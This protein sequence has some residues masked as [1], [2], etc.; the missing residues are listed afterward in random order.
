MVSSLVIGSSKGIGNSISKKLI[1][2][3]HKVIGV[4][5]S[6]HEIKSD[7]FSHFTLDVSNSNSFLEFLEKPLIKKVDNIILCA[8]TNDVAPLGDISEDRIIKLYKVNLFPAFNLL[9]KISQKDD[10]P[11][12]IVFISSIWS[13][14]GITGRSMYGTSKGALVALAKHAS[15]ELSKN[16][17]FVNCISPGFTKT[18]L[19]N[20]T[21]DDPDIIKS[22]KRT[23]FNKMQ[24]TSAISESIIM[25]L[26]PNNHGITGQE[27]F[28]D[29]GFSAH[30]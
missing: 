14:F 21:K 9:K 13:S 7:N 3:N 10:R 23:A 28:V 25:L 1:Q 29:S 17:I 19:T 8:G 5:R 30:A 4:S 22:L 18:E 11:K 6:K 2:Q 20:K 24:E 26:I 15:A 16:S 12:S 27:I